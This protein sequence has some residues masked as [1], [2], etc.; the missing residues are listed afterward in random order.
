MSLYDLINDRLANTPNMRELRAEVLKDA[1][2]RT[3][4]VGFGTGLNAALYPE[5]VEQVVAVEPSRGAEKKAR[6]RIARAKVPIEW[7][8]ASGEQLPFPDASFDTAV[9]TLV[10]CTKHGDVRAILSEIRRV[11]RPGGRYLFLEHGQSVTEQG[12]KLQR[13]LN[14]LH[15]LLI[16]CR[17]DVPIRARLE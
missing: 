8:Q 10:L 9:T 13:R 16:G 14:P 2:G 3:L 17:L 6:M 7:R 4:E 11:L 12:Q 5:Q 1:R 15:K